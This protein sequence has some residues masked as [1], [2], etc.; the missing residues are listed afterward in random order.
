MKKANKAKKTKSNKKDARKKDK[1][2]YDNKNRNSHWTEEPKGRYIDFADK[3]SEGDGSNKYKDVAASAHRVALKQIE[4]KNKRKR[5]VAMIL[6]AVLLIAIGYVGMDVRMIRNAEPLETLLKSSSGTDSSVSQISLELAAEKI[7]SVSLDNSAML[8]SVISTAHDVG[9]NSVVFDAK[10]ADG[11]IG[12]RSSLAAVDTYSAMSNVGND[13][14]GSIK[15]L[16]K[17]DILPVARISCYVDNVAP[18]QNPSMAVSDANGVYKDKDGDSYLNPDSEDAYGYIRD[19]IRELNDIG[20]QVFILYGYD[21]PESISSNYNDGF[22]TLADKLNK[23]FDGK[24][25]LIR[26]KT[27]DIKGVDSESEKVT[28]AKITEEIKALPS[29]DDNEIYAVNSSVEHKKLYELLSE[30]GVNNFILE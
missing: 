23:E 16:I 30:N 27:V 10:R 13:S 7:E 26:E 1:R 15:K 6:V 9:C 17:N 5:T 25:K 8:D 28:D 3:Y 22:D 11:T 20:I 18:V 21:L 29:L 24:I 19:I 2:F 4:K 12:Y 14:T